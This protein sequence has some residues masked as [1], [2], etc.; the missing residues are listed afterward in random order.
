MPAAVRPRWRA[1]RGG[2]PQLAARDLGGGVLVG[3]CERHDSSTGGCCQ[4]LVRV[5]GRRSAGRL[6]GCR[7]AV[8]GLA[9]RCETG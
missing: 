6:G 9:Q 8:C 4:A 1:D 7:R 5:L 3:G 2:C